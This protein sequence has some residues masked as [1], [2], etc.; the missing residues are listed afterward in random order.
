V[1]GGLQPMFKITESLL[2]DP[3]FIEDL[4]PCFSEVSRENAAKKI[5]SGDLCYTFWFDN[6]I[7]GVMGGTLS[8]EKHMYG[9]S[10]LG[11]GIF[12]CQIS[13]A[14]SMKKFINDYFEQKKLDRFCVTVDSDNEAAI[15]QNIWM[16]LQVEGTLRK[17][18][19]KG[20]DQVI[21]AKVRE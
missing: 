17:S 15:K 5:F 20:Q 7:V 3:Y 11:K 2:V 21:L 9:W 19:E 8:T 13:F 14:K 10:I 6:K 1:Q 18:G 12:K 16:G 4:L